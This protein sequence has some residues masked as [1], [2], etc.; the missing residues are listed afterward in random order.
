MKICGSK[1]TPDQ[2]R[3]LDEKHT[4]VAAETGNNLP[5]KRVPAVVIQIVVITGVKSSSRAGRPAKQRLRSQA[6]VDGVLIE[7]ET[8]KGGFGELISTARAQDVHVESDSIGV[9]AL[10][11]LRVDAELHPQFVGRLISEIAIELKQI[12]TS[13]IERRFLAQQQR[14]RTHAWILITVA[15]VEIEVSP[16]MRDL[17]INLNLLAVVGT[18]EKR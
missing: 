6:G 16:P 10:Q 13:R 12:S 18:S 9:I 2:V 14:R 7:D 5:C 11:P 17:T 3:H 4:R 1:T 15:E 8:R